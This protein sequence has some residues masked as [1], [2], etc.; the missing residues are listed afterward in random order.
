LEDDLCEKCKAKK[1]DKQTL[2]QLEQKLSAIIREARDAD[3]KAEDIEDAVYD[4][5][6]VNPNR[7]PDI[8]TRTPTELL[9]VIAPKG[10]EADVALD[11]LQQLVSK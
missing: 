9:A 11:H 8:D 5:K 7:P 4:L 1:T 6:A 2:E 3:A 10:R